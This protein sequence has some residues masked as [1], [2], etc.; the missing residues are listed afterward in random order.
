MPS[1]SGA[2]VQLRAWLAQR[3]LKNDARLPPERELCVLLGVSRGELRKALDVLEKEGS[4]WRQVGKGTFVG[5]RPMEE[6]GSL[7]AIAAR[8]SPR[9][10]MHARLTFEPVLAFEAALNATPSHFDELRRCLAC[11]RRAT[12]WREYET[13]DNRFHRTVA[14]ASGNTVLTALFNQLNAIRRTVVWTRGRNHTDVPPINHHS[15]DEH[16]Q[17]FAAIEDRDPRAAQMA[18]SKHL[19][20]VEERLLRVTEAAE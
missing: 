11:T 15:F 1:D 17:I 5:I 2:L 3:E 13:G 4:V 7:D 20:S 18:M 6:M 8:S 12:T 19:R 14:D 10:V 9:E 16:D